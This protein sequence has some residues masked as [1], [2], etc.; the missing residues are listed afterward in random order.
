MT[1]LGARVE[2]AKASLTA[3]STLSDSPRGTM[4]M[5]INPQFRIPPHKPAELE[6]NSVPRTYRRI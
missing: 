3:A 2:V 1:R 5:Y 4:Y 6:E